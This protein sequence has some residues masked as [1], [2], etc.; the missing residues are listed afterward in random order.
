MKHNPPA[1]GDNN[2]LHIPRICAVFTEWDRVP[3]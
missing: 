3:L 2:M 1:G